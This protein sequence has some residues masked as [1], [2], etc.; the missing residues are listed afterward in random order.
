MHNGPRVIDS[1]PCT[2]A[3]GAAENAG[4]SVGRPRVCESDETQRPA[5]SPHALPL[6]HIAITPQ[7]PTSLPVLVQ[8]RHRSNAKSGPIATRPR[9]RRPLLLSSRP[10]PAARCC[11]R[12]KRAGHRPERIMREPRCSPIARLLGASLRGLRY[13]GISQNLHAAL[14]GGGQSARRGWVWVWPAPCRHFARQSFA[15]GALDAVGARV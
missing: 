3:H 4:A 11:N 1:H 8:G 7:S 6:P 2:P 12:V 9:N 10:E 13:V 5:A 14:T 15:D